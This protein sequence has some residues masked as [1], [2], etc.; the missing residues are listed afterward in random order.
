MKPWAIILGRFLFESRDALYNS[1][2]IQILRSVSAAVLI[3]VLLVFVVFAIIILPVH[4]RGLVPIKEYRTDNM[5]TDN[6]GMQTPVLSVFAIMNLANPAARNV[7]LFKAAVNVTPLWNEDSPLKPLCEHVVGS[8]TFNS[9]SGN[10][11]S[12]PY[13]QTIKIVCPSRYAVLGRN[14]T[15]KAHNPTFAADAIIDARLKTVSIVV[16]LAANDSDV[17]STT[18]PIPIYPESRMLGSIGFSLRRKYL[19]PLW[20]TFASALASQRTFFVCEILTMMPDPSSLIPRS[21]TAGTLRLYGQDDNS[22]WRVNSDHREHDIFGGI[23]TSGGFWTSING[24]FAV[25]FGSHLLWVI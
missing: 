3:L 18:P 22:E 15:G 7:E 14:P 25:F 10:V 21:N 13:I 12:L 8:T 6:P 5:L 2:H 23:G 16:G 19:K 1:R 20:A 17:L 11:P 9:P 4:E 24:I